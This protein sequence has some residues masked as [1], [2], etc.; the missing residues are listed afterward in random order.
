LNG[1]LLL[2]D[3]VDKTTGEKSLELSRPSGQH[4]GFDQVPLFFCFFFG[5]DGKNQMP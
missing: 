4:F 1:L 3:Y 2:T 5:A